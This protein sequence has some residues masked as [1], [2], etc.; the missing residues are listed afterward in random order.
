M[1]Q[2]SLKIMSK[3]G[4]FVY[5]DDKVMCLKVWSLRLNSIY[6]IF[7]SKFRVIL[8]FC[9]PSSY[10]CRVPHPPIILDILN[11]QC[12]VSLETYEIKNYP[13]F[14][15]YFVFVKDLL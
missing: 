8:Q 6:G 4:R 5:K 7:F 10:A 14:L 12:I 3:V 1:G 15:P 11:N 9:T 2:N 13:G